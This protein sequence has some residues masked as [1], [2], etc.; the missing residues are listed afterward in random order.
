M[1][2]AFPAI[3]PGEPVSLDALRRFKADLQAAL[4]LVERLEAAES[5]LAGG[6]TTPLSARAVPRGELRGLARV[7]AAIDRQIGAQSGRSAQVRLAPMVASQPAS[8]A[9]K[10]LFGLAR[11]ARAIN[12]QFS[13]QMTD[14]AG[15]KLVTLT[16]E[17]GRDWLA[18]ANEAADA[19]P[20]LTG[21]ARAAAA[22]NL[23]LLGR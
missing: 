8:G 3:V 5:R 13:H 15:V 18:K 6:Q 22:I 2:L 7:A 20:R 11:A 4:A 17:C 16:A 21:L 1:T 12:Q 19:R 10:P 9:A 23:Q 14:M